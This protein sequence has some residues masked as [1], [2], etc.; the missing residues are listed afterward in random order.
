M[1]KDAFG[2]D[3]FEGECMI[4]LEGLKDQMKHDLWF[5]LLDARQQPH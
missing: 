5:D 2:N 4:S 1:D 3:D